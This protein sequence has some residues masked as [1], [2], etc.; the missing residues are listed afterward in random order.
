MYPSNQSG[1]PNYDLGQYHGKMFLIEE[2]SKDCDY[3]LIKLFQ[4]HSSNQSGRPNYDLGQY[5]R[6]MFLNKGLRLIFN[7][8]FPDVP[9]KL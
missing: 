5:H 9:V 3:H 8:A 1:H 4:M 7:Q 6:K 2:K